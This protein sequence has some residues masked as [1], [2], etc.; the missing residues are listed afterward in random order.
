MHGYKSLQKRL[1]ALERRLA[2]LPVPL[3]LEERTCQDERRLELC[4]AALEG[5]EPG[6]LGGGEREFFQ[7]I[8]ESAP[9]F[10]ELVEEGTLD[11]YL[12]GDDH[13]VVDED[14]NGAPAWRP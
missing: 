11:A 3:S 10:R 14:G 5:V 4:T 8:K 1:E 12:D 9:V 7:K 2:G 13:D 6:N